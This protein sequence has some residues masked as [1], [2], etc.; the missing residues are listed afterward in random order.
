[1]NDFI[2]FDTTEPCSWWSVY[3]LQNPLPGAHTWTS[4]CE[5]YTPEVPH[6]CVFCA[7]PLGSNTTEIQSVNHSTRQL[8]S[9][10]TGYYLDHQLVPWLV[11]WFL[12]CLVRWLGRWFVTLWLRMYLVGSQDSIVSKSA[13][14]GL[15]DTEFESPREHESFLFSK[16]SR[17]HLGPAQ[18]PLQWARG[19]LLRG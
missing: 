7:K 17:P 6:I 10:L 19:F 14:C 3:I 12:N 15:D 2:S 11:K 9:Y 8:S 16:T 1:M 5:V 13:G 18:P 4:P